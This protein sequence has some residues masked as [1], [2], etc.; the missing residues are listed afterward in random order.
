MNSKVRYDFLSDGWRLNPVALMMPND[1][2][3]PAPDPRVGL[4]TGFAHSSE[5]GPLSPD[6]PHL[7]TALPGPKTQAL[8]ERDH[9]VLSPSYTRGYPLSIAK[10]EGAMVIDLD[11]NRFLDFCAGIAVTS[12]GH[13]HPQIVKAI[14]DQAA[15]FL[16]MSGTDFYYEV[17]V[18]LAEKL[19]ATFP[20]YCDARVY[21]GNSGAEAVE[22]A[23]KLARFKTKRS[24]I[25]SFF[26]SFHGRTYGAMS[27]TASKAIQKDGFYPMVPN[28][29]HAHYPYPYRDPFHSS[30]PDECADRCLEYLETHLFK[31]VVK[32]DQVAAFIVEPVQGEGGYIVPPARFMLGLQALARKHGILIISD[33]VQAGIGRTGKFWG[34]ELFDGYEPDIIASAKGLASGMPLS[35][36]ITRH[37]VMNW[38]PGAHAS[39]FGGNPVCCAAALET[40]ALVQGQY[41]HNAAVEGAFILDQLHGMMASHP[42][43]GQVRGAGLMIGVEIVKNPATREKAPAWRDAIVDAC[44]DRGLLVL[45]CGEN[46]IRLSPP[47]VINRTQSQAAVT[48]LSEA[49]KQVC[50]PSA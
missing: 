41:Q 34:C 29:H 31:A 26:R 3:N 45:G 49:V 20:G 36:V 16:H 50:G 44:F 23:I 15:Q 5:S 10:G 22:A 47:L 14:Q 38:P 25:V 33:E 8:M 4:P 6:L 46:S 48:I 11:G 40:L 21:F 2:P 37:C 17:M 27:V 30:S 7:V 32:P 18:E 35:A 12:T 43:I 39:T 1:R 9:K 42:A 28:V 13:S 24:H 19:A